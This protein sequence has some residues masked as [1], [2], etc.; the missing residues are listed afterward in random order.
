VSAQSLTTY[1]DM[2]YTPR[3]RRPNLKGLLIVI[4]LVASPMNT[5]QPARPH[6]RGGRGAIDALSARLFPVG[7]RPRRARICFTRHQHFTEQL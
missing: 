5:R 3:F 7:L 2:R 4:A 1:L 6:R